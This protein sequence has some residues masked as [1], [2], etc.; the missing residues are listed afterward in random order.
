MV[1]TSTP[2]VRRLT[3]WLTASAAAAAVAV[4]AVAAPAANATVGARPIAK[5][6]SMVTLG[7]SQAGGIEFMDRFCILPGQTAT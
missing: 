3:R 5:P 6:G 1:R 2:R 4:P 7:C